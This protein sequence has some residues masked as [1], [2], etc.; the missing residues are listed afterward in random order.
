MNCPYCGKERNETDKYCIFCGKKT[1]NGNLVNS[2]KTMDAVN[3][4]A[5]KMADGTVNSIM[6]TGGNGINHMVRS[7]FFGFRNFQLF[8]VLI[9]VVFGVLKELLRWR[10]YDGAAVFTI[11]Q[12]MA[13]IMFIIFIG[14]DIYIH[15]SELGKNIVDEAARNAVS[16]LKDRAIEKFNVDGDQIKEIEPIVISGAGISPV[17]LAPGISAGI[18]GFAGIFKK[19]YSKDPIEAYR[20]GHDG[21]PRYLLI[22]TTLFAFT[23]TQ[24]LVYS[25]N[26][27][28]STGIIYDEKISE[29]F[30]KDVN[31]VI[32]QNVLKKFKAGIFKRIYYSL[33]Y[34][35]LDVCGVSKI[36]AFDSRFA[37]NADTSLA[38]MES[39]IR[40]KK[41]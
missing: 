5:G 26:M 37:E 21:A 23:E 27:D 24:L 29:I 10:W 31:C 6:G 30:Y 3:A 41:Y 35:N 17:S 16:K 18:R 33:K 7:Y 8:A 34:L 28:I 11:L 19:F 12:I 32:Y 25:G 1:E 14:L 15:F 36:A 9:W 39:Y 20:M 2:S 22:Q 38:G 4:F 13:D 40:E